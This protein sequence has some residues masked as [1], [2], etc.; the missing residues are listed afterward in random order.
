MKIKRYKIV[1]L[2]F[3]LFVFIIG[4]FFI[5]PAISLKMY[6][7][8]S[9]IFIGV[10][11]VRYF[12]SPDY[13]DILKDK[14]RVWKLSGY[15]S[16]LALSDKKIYS[17]SYGVWVKSNLILLVSYTLFSII[18]LFTIFNGNMT[19]LFFWIHIIILIVLQIFAWIYTNF[20]EKN[21]LIRRIFE[22]K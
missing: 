16:K 14:Q 6:F 7:F 8:S 22:Q 4:H 5:K 13:D 18:I 21:K 10:Y 1:D 15:Y 20:V 11:V 12:F 3:L 19:K 2:V 17:Y 9:I